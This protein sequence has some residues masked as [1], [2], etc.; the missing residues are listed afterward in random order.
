MRMALGP[1]IGVMICFALVG[2]RASVKRPDR[3]DGRTI[4]P[5][6]PRQS[7]DSPPPASARP[8]PA[9]L[10]GAEAKAQLAVRAGTGTE[11]VIL[12]EFGVKTTRIQ[13]ADGATGSYTTGGPNGPEFE[14]RAAR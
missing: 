9:V 14:Y 7:Q 8:E 3:I 5:C 10:R 2:C 13:Y 12:G 1:A 6:L 4:A 11:T